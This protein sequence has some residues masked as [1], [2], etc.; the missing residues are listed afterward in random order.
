MLDTEGRVTSISAMVCRLMVGPLL[1]LDGLITRV[2]WLWH[3]DDKRK[4]L[5]GGHDKP[6]Y[7]NN[8]R[9]SPF[10]MTVWIMPSRKGNQDKENILKSMRKANKK[11]RL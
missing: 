2:Y 9:K 10:A 7:I 4:R 3:E 1:K 5:I 6:L 11:Y 8:S